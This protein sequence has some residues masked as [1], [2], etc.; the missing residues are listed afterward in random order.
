M[1]YKEIKQNYDILYNVKY[2]FNDT[3]KLAYLTQEQYN[4]ICDAV[5]N[6]RR[7]KELDGH[8]CAVIRNIYKHHRDNFY[9]IKELEYQ[10]PRLHA[11]KFI[12]KKKIR[13][14]IFKRDK[15]KCLCCRGN[16]ILTID[17]IVPIYKGGVN[18][19]YNLQT[20]C[21]SCNSSKGTKII[22]YRK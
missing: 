15:Y 17:H 2:G 11:Q 13:E 22:D 21:K 8:S 10:E 5:S 6:L 19:L 7:L 18:R 3:Y 1:A 9:K 12:G 16:N 4:R 14:F 20:L